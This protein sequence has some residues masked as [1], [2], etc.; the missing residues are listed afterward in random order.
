MTINTDQLINLRLRLAIRK[1]MLTFAERRIY[2]NMLLTRFAWATK[3]QCAQVI[4]EYVREGLFTEE[5]GKQ[6]SVI[7][8]WNEGALR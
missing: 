6:G 7:L 5:N 2:K 3:E 1:A 4:D 8:I